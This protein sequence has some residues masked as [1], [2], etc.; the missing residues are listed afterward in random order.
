MEDQNTLVA[1]VCRRRCKSIQV[2]QV[3]DHHHAQGELM[4]KITVAQ[5]IFDKKTRSLYMFSR[6][7][8]PLKSR[9]QEQKQKNPNKTSLQTYVRLDIIVRRPQPRDNILRF[10]AQSERTAVKPAVHR[11][12]TVFHVRKE[13]IKIKQKPIYLN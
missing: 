1:F 10:P 3:P 8:P 5:I 12:P 6:V 2:G 7:T 4:Y 9:F 11:L 13:S